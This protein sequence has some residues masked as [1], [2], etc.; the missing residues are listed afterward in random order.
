M[1]TEDKNI[2]DIVVRK[3]NGFLYYTI[4]YIVKFLSKL[5]FRLKIDKKEI[6]GLKGPFMVIANH[7]SLA[8]IAFTVSALLPHRL[9]ILTSRDL[10]TWKLFKPFIERVGCIS[11]NQFAIDIMALKTLKAAVEQGRNVALYPE[12]KASLD[13]KNLHY[14]PPSIAKLIKFLDVPVVLSYSQGAYLVKP[15]YYK[16]FRYGQV[17]IKTSVLLTQ[18]QVRKLSNDEIYKKVVD[19]LQ[20][21]DHIFQQENKARF[22]SSKPARGLEYILY[23][24]PKC[25]LDYLMRTTDRNLICDYCGNN[26]EYTEYGELIP[27]ATSKAFKRIDLWY[28]YQRKVIDEEIRKDDFYISHKVD[29]F[30]EVDRKYVPIGEGELYIDKEYIGYKGTKNGQPFECKTALK[31][32]HTITVKNQEG[33][34]LIYPEGTYRF[35]FKDKKYSVKYGLIVE[36]MYRYIHNLDGKR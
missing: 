20:F 15:R 14:I 27:D 28:D 9:N 11:K 24:C 22:R 25:S 18:E 4:A 16:G 30:M 7:S 10:F 29:S 17:R 3:P 35:L 31:T 21:N 1:I 12:G 2:K 19:A 26:V 6:K 34:D 8:D 33:V 5:L 13:G 32:L 36:Q 23:R